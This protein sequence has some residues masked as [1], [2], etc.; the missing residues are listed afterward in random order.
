MTTARPRQRVPASA[1]LATAL[2]AL[3]L[4]ACSSTPN[5][6]FSPGQ[7]SGPAR[8]VDVSGI[9]DAVPR[10]EPRSKYG[11]PSS[12]V[13][14]GHRYHVMQNAHGYRAR[15]IASWYGRKFHGRRT[16]NGERY[17][18]Y[19]MSAAHKEL[20]LPTYCR[21]TNL[22]NGRSVIVRVNDR[23]P[24]HANRIIDL[25]YAA[26]KKLDIV[27]HG[28]APVEVEAL[29]PYRRPGHAPPAPRLASSSEPAP[30]APH[31]VGLYLQV[32]AFASRHNA[33]RL[34]E[35]LH[36]EFSS[37]H[38]QAGRADAQPIYRVRIGPFDSTD[39]VDTTAD[40]LGRFG[41]TTATVVV[42]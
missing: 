25:S 4:S 23:G 34:R 5:R 29:D 14:A 21:V 22:N 24:F 15:G 39:E 28:T 11:N 26:A 37:I 18:M 12:Y 20:P 19:A 38:I 3:A 6:G 32:G 27:A 41:I 10:P 31:H 40:R 17:D 7:D 42:D 8:V 9:P 1:V 33:E 13:V 16:S 2:A 36:G 35:R 30:A